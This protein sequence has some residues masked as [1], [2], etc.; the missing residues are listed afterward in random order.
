L[1]RV[2]ERPNE[3]EAVDKLKAKVYDMLA[4]KERPKLEE[5]A[6]LALADGGALQVLVDG[7]VSKEDAYRYN[8]FEVLMRVSEDQPAA[9]YSEWDAF[10]EML[11]SRNAFF[12]SI[13]L[14]LIANLTGADG[15]G[16]FEALFDRYF[17]LL[18]DEKVMVARYLV[19]G[20]EGIAKRK[21]HL[22]ERITER[23]LDIDK[24]HHAEGRK[25]LIKADALGYF[26]AVLA[27]SSEKERML[28]LAEDL[29]ASSSPKARKAAKS[30]LSQHGEM[31]GGLL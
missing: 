7:L 27:E 21:P 20:A 16:R 3:G 29:L 12:R 4:S 1:L 30:F 8:C 22:Q 31:T 26:E 17:G 10:V 24:T 15:E 28:A 18:D 14:R 13:G 6:R 2:C 11:G 5:A 19:Q 25:A 9:L 23:L